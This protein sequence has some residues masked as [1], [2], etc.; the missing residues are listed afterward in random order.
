VRTLI[1]HAQGILH[2]IVPNAG[3][4]RWLKGAHFARKLMAEGAVAAGVPYNYVEAS[5]G[6]PSHGEITHDTGTLLLLISEV[7]AGG[8][9]RQVAFDLA[10]AGDIVTIGTQSATLTAPPSQASDIWSFYVDAWPAITSGLTTLNI[11]R[12]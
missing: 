9:P 11:T 12:P 1:R 5:S 8:T 4:R 7:D 10:Q 2:A 3:N 6:T